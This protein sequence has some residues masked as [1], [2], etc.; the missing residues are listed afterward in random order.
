M[1]T[2]SP[3]K[4][5]SI[6]VLFGLVCLHSSLHTPN[7]KST[8]NGQ[9]MMRLSDYVYDID[10]HIVDRNEINECSHVFNQEP[11]PV[12]LRKRVIKLSIAMC[13]AAVVG[14]IFIEITVAANHTCKKP[15]FSRPFVYVV[16]IS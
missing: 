10:Q 15:R 13:F 14:L 4:V 5:A 11:Q 16:G 7:H 6:S 9:S 12:G 1:F 2:V 3:T 8:A